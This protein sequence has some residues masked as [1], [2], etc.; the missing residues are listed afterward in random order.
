MLCDL[1]IFHGPRGLFSCNVRHGLYTL[2]GLKL[3]K[4]RENMSETVLQESEVAARGEGYVVVRGD[5]LG[6]AQEI[7]AG[8]H[9]RARQLGAPGGPCADLQDRR[10]RLQ[11]LFLACYVHRRSPCCAKSIAEFPRSTEVRPQ[12]SRRHR[13]C[14]NPGGKRLGEGGPCREPPPE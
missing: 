8:R 10:K 11:Q 12:R 7:Q 1:P 9:A 6:F 3:D 5:A 13:L 2:R 14:E 4:G